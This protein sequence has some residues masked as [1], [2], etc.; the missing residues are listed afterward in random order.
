MTF[1]RD[2]S[3]STIQILIFTLCYHALIPQLFQVVNKY[4]YLELLNTFTDLQKPEHNLDFR[5]TVPIWT[6]LLLLFL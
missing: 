2:Q 5:H 3:G 6:K 1:S 4:I